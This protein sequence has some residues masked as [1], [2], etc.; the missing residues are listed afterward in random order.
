MQDKVTGSILA[1]DLD[2]TL[3]RTD[4]LHESVLMLMKQ[5]PLYIFLLP[6]WLMRGK[7]HLK[8]MVADRVDP[9][10]GIPP[11]LPAPTPP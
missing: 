4:L 1:V 6:L 7:A 11:G 3:V 10:T 9:A 2:G 5:N 8:Q